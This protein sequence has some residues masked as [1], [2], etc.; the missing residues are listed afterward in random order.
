LRFDDAQEWLD[1]LQLHPCGV[2]NYLLKDSPRSLTLGYQCPRCGI[3][4]EV[5]LT[6]VARVGA[7]AELLTQE[8]RVKLG[9]LLGGF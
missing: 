8:S 9:A 6:A 2:K 7:P 5:P 3:V 4:F 1:T